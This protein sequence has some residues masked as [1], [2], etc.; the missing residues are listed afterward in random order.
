MSDSAVMDSTELEIQAN[1][2]KSRALVEEL[3][4]EE[5]KPNTIIK[6]KV[7]ELIRENVVGKDMKTADAMKAFNVSWRQIQHIKAK[8][9]NQVKARTKHPSKFTEDMKTKLLL[10][11]DQKS[12]T[13]LPEMAKFILEQFDIKVLTQTVSNLIHDMDISWKQVTN[14]PAAWNRTD[15]IEQRTNFVG[16]RGSDLGRKVVFID[17]AGFDLHSGQPAVLSLVPKAKQVTLIGALSVDGFDYYE[18]L[19]ADNTKAK[20]VGADETLVIASRPSELHLD[21][22]NCIWTLGIASGRL[23]LH[24]DA[25]NHIWTLGIASGRSESHLDARNRIWTL[26]IAPGRSESHLDARN[27]T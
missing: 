25:W 27:H 1:E 18:L 6:P 21:P 15:L 11:L 24:L 14:I 17:E 26:G 20:G 3:D 4:Q 22:R 23:E 13:T 7:R 8:D 16:R 2:E 10:E 19:N 5:R 9:P 12:T